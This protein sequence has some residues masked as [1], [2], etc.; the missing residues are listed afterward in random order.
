L[1]GLLVGQ[2][3]HTKPHEIYR[4][5]IESTAFGALTI[6]D[7]IEEY[8]VNIDEVVTCGGLAYKNP[9]LLQIYAD[10]CN[11]AMKVSGSRQT[12]ALGAAIFGSVAAGVERGGHADVMEA[13]K[14]MTRISEIYEPDPGRVEVYRKLYRFYRQ[15]HDGFGIT[16]RHDPMYGIMKG[17]LSI[18][19][20]VRKERT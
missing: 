10:V 6:I 17:L 16:D 15:L 4:A 19:D 13:Q 20:Q 3:L 7:R 18:R 5:L 11:R 14:A 2:T 1:T 12:P 8:G 9:L